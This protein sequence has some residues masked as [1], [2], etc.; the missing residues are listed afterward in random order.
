[1]RTKPKPAGTD[2]RVPRART[3]HWSQDNDYYT[4][5]TIADLRD[6]VSRRRVGRPPISFSGGADEDRHEIKPPKRKR[7]S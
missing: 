3:N 2:D 1:M 6:A 5:L 4:F 7:T